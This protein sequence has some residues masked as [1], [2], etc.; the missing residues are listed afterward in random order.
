MSERKTDFVNPTAAFDLARACGAGRRLVGGEWLFSADQLAYFY[1][2]IKRIAMQRAA[3]IAHEEAEKLRD[4]VP[5]FDSEISERQA[6][7]LTD[8]S[9]MLHEEARKP[10]F[11]TQDQWQPVDILRDETRLVQFRDGSGNR[12]IASLDTWSMN[13]G[14]PP[15][16]WRPVI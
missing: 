5:G 1:N 16:M 13:H 14:H 9:L 12:W 10:I 15:V 3:V 4:H 11:R 2:V 7:A 6:D 8:L